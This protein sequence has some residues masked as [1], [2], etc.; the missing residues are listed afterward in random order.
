MF[1]PMFKQ[2][3][4]AVSPACRHVTV[5]WETVTAGDLASRRYEDQVNAITVV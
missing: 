1:R 3:Q 2:W 4:L 5:A